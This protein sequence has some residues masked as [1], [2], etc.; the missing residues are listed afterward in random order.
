MSKNLI[1]VASLLI[2]VSSMKADF[3]DN[4]IDKV[5]NKVTDK[6]SDKA[7]EKAGHTVDKLFEENKSKEVSD[8]KNTDKIAKLK[9]LIMM[10]EKGYLSNSEFEKEKKILLKN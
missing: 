3:F 5:S 8:Y 1:L 9:E 7:T 6:V 4:L 2:S 10:K